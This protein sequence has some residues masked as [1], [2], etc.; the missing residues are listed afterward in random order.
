MSEHDFGDHQS[1]MNE[2]SHHTPM[3]REEVD[4][5]VKAVVSERATFTD[6]VKVAL[7]ESL[8]EWLDEK[9]MTFGKWSVTSLA[10]LL[11]VAL[12]W[13]ILRSQGWQAPR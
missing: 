8:K 1:S 10:C 13:F 9:F 6:A 5:I 11:L 7:K 4:R 2:P 12:V 3:T